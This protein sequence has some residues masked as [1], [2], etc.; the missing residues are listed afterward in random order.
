MQAQQ[1]VLT[2]NEAEKSLGGR[3]LKIA[4]EIDRVE[5]Y[6]E[7]HAIAIAWTA[8][9][10]GT[11]M[12]LHGIDLTALK[13]AALAHD[14][15]E[16]A[17]KRDY[18]LRPGELS[19]EETLDLWRHPILGEQAAGELK[20]PRQAQ[21]LIR[22]HHEWWNGGGYPDG[23]AGDAIPPGARI[24][25][26][27][28][29]YFALISD[30]PHRRRLDKT[31]AE[32]IIADMAGIEFDPQVAKLLLQ[33][34]TEETVDSTFAYPIS[35]GDGAVTRLAEDLPQPLV[36]VVY[37]STDTSRREVIPVEFPVVDQNAGSGLASLNAPYE[38]LT[39]I[40]D[41][42]PTGIDKAG[43]ETRLVI[44]SVDAPSSEA[45]LEF[46]LETPMAPAAAD[47][48]SQEAIEEAVIEGWPEIADD[49]LTLSEPSGEIPGK[50]QIEIV[51]DG[52]ASPSPS[53]TLDGTEVKSQTEAH[54]ADLT[55]S[56]TPREASE[57]DQMKSG[58][59]DTNLSP[60]KHKEI[61]S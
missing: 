17:M 15:G 40:P 52:L 60:E 48:A 5:G 31:E 56:Q 19:W 7:P 50:S 47:F 30:R 24:L 49:G 44:T 3:L 37:D 39:Q 29:S 46:E 16:R 23:L 61:E 14:L 2:F 6:S 10:I 45:S 28:D 35:G 59:S 54:A 57:E 27:V 38:S 12:G 26:A 51:Q 41:E 36:E 25:R 22:W 33:V 9:K 11:R 4:I 1:A 32:Q 13:F 8:E 20:L 55:S 18:L 43:N 53:Q 21:L 58:G 42:V 34:L